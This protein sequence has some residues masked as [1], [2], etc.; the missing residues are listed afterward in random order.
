MLTRRSRWTLS[1]GLCLAGSWCWGDELPPAPLAEPSDPTII[2]T[3]ATVP[4]APVYESVLEGTF[5]QAPPVPMAPAAPPKKP[6]PPAFPLPKTLPPTGPWKPVFF[7]NDFSYKKD[8]QHEHL[9]GE[10]LKDMQFMWFD[11]PLTISTGGE[12]RHRHMNED[13]RLRP[14]GP[15]QADYDLWRWRH[16][17]DAKFGDFRIYFE[18]IDAESFGNDAP[19]QPIDVNRWDL[20]NLF[21]DVALLETDFATHTLRYGRQELLFGRQRLVS[22]LDWAN[23]RRNF[24]GARYMIKGA[25]FKWDFFLTR[26]VNSAT[27]FATVAANDNKFDQPNY[28]V[29]F[30][31]SYLSYTG[32]KNTTIEGYWMYLDTGTIQIPTR[33]DGQRH[34]LGTRFAH[35]I[36]IVDGNGNEHRVWDFDTEGGF[37]FGNDGP[38]NVNAG[39]YTLVAGHTWKKVLWTPRV[40][41][42]FYYGSGDRNAG[43]VNNNTFNTLFPLGHAYWGLSDNLSGQN[44]LNY[45]LQADVRPTKKFAV[46]SAVHWFQLASNGDTLYNVGGAPVGTPGNGRDVGQSCDLYGY[47]AFNPNFDISAGYSWF[48]YGQYIDNVAPRGDATQF[49]I[50]TSLRY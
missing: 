19:D 4:P 35:L 32:I 46:T 21:L 7:D 20:Q 1:L 25:D 37:Q 6:A 16:Y 11:T 13:N 18:G 34:L 3:E 24:E 49:Y 9:L 10:E 45:T 23:T 29:W 8:P 30:A 14:G 40:A 38:A 48:W 50:Q 27:G 28:D 42:L 12:I 41:G 44:L 5:L 2:L 43:G 47:Y 17:V 15:V 36:P 26:P 33:P 31:G 39:F 22:P